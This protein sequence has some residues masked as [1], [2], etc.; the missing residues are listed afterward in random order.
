[1]VPPQLS[2]PPSL[3][4]SALSLLFFGLFPFPSCWAVCCVT[5]LLSLNALILRCWS[6]PLMSSKA[7]GCGGAV[8]RGGGGGR[9]AGACG[10]YLSRCRLHR[11][12]DGYVPLGCASHQSDFC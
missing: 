6:S 3:L 12:L 5:L 7:N 4:S 10:E 9:G 11:E 1:M 2:L 8:W